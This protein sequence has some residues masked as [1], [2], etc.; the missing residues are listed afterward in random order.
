VRLVTI[1]VV[2]GWPLVVTKIPWVLATLTAR[3]VHWCLSR[4]RS[5]ATASHP[6]AIRLLN[7]RLRLP[8]CHAFHISQGTDTS[9][10]ILQIL[11]LLHKVLTHLLLVLSQLLKTVFPAVPLGFEH[12]S[13]GFGCIDLQRHR[14]LSLTLLNVVIINIVDSI[15]KITHVQ[16]QRVVVHQFNV[17]YLLVYVLVPRW[18]LSAGFRPHLGGTG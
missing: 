16:G 2:N 14:L 1:A 11:R 7:R 5:R 10:K 18:N 15:V 3:A 17:V 9:L 13:L 8:A 6:L 12:L 4:T